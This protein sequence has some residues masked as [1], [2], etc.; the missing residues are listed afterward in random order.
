MEYSLEEVAEIPKDGRGDRVP[1]GFY[2]D[3]IKVF[4]ENQY[5][6]AKLTVPGKNPDTI[7]RR[8]SYR[9]TSGMSAICRE[10]GVYLINHNLVSPE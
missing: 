10:G 6:R 5:P 7:H 1:A 3:I 4:I 9:M 8:L 2:E